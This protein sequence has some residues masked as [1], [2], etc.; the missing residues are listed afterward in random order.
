[1]EEDAVRKDEADDVL[2]GQVDI[3]EILKEIR[4]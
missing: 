1:M 4:I 3:T 2:V